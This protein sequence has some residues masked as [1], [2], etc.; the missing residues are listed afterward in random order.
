M[1]L[2]LLKRTPGPLVCQGLLQF[3]TVWPDRAIFEMSYNSGPSIWQLF[4]LFGKRSSLC[5]TDV[6]NIWATIEKYHF[7]SPANGRRVN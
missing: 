6:A 7:L 5:E 2:K 4:R 3:R 1:F